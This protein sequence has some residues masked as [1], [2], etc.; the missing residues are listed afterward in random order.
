MTLTNRLSL[1]FL[2]TLAVVLAGFS[3]L[4]YCLAHHAL[5]QQVDDR[6]AAVLDT[7]AAAAEVDQDGIEW[8]PHERFLPFGDDRFATFLW[9]VRDERGQRRDGSRHGE[10]LFANAVPENGEEIRNDVLQGGKRW[11]LVTKRLLAPSTNQERPKRPPRR[12]SALTLAVA[13]PLDEV[14]SQLHALALTLTLLSF[15][16]WGGAAFA[17]RSLCRKALMPLTR[18]AHASRA[19]QPGDLHGRLPAPETHDELA[20]LCVAF[21][22]LLGRLQESYERQRRF[23]AEASHQLRTPLT[24]MLG[25]VEVALRRERSAEENRRVL[26]L[27]QK[28]ATQL[29]HIVEQLLFLARADA[30]AQ[31]PEGERLDLVAWTIEH[32]QSWQ[33]CRRQRDLT[34][35]TPPSVGPLWVK[36]HPALLAQAIDNL[37]DNACKYSEPGAPISLAAGQDG[38]DVFLTVEDRGCGI[39]TEDLAH[40]FDPFFRAQEGRKRG[41]SGIGLGLAVT[42]RIITAFGGTVEAT[43]RVGQGSRFTVRLSAHPFSD[44]DLS[45]S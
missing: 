40:V 25:Q 18:M 8:D 7:L 14:R 23:T 21:N 28:Q 37:L 43:S 26:A 11:R 5:H 1:F 41:I 38:E 15:G 29:R 33:D 24:A 4:L 19:I 35:A 36:V 12:H 39:C 34:F 42:R 27:V 20:E 44:H 31:L 32:L 17:G 13:I 22:D 30:E 2:G 6:A 9:C 45:L 10:G 16:L 3:G